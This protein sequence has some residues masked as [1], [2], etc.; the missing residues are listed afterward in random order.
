MHKI[1]EGGECNCSPNSSSRL[2]T[3]AKWT[4]YRLSKTIFPCKNPGKHMVG[5]AKRAVL[6]SIDKVE[7]HMDNGGSV[8]ICLRIDRLPPAPIRLV[9]LDRDRPGSL[10]WLRDRGI[11]SPLE[12]IGKRGGHDYF[13]L[14]DSAPDLKSDTSRLNPGKSHPTTEEKP[15]IDIKTSGLVVAA[16]SVNK[17]L[18][19]EGRDISCE[20]ETV[21]LIFASLDSIRASLPEFDPRS[22]SPGMSVH[23][24]AAEDEEAQGNFSEDDF[25]RQV[26]P[27]ERLDAYRPSAETISGPLMGVR[28]SARKDDARMFIRKTEPGIT[29]QKASAN[30]FRVMASMLRHYWLSE[31]DTFKYM[32]RYYASRCLDENGNVNRISDREIARLILSARGKDISDPIGRWDKSEFHG[33]TPEIII[34]NLVKRGARKRDKRRLR[35]HRTKIFKESTIEAFLRSSGS[36]FNAGVSVPHPELL[37]RCNAWIHEHFKGETVTGKR[38]SMVLDRLHFQTFQDRIGGKRVVMVEPMRVEP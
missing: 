18:Y 3:N 25:D 9:I 15:G 24:P 6:S 30:H 27:Q 22:I 33:T 36:P 31:V 28:Y 7:D 19:W 37:A 4:E 12:V 32:R 35:Q 21:A 1:K 23:V 10:E 38:L 17:T 29:G 16:Y 2:D 11:S 5:S 13:V 26:E 14:P 20:P 34:R 8:G